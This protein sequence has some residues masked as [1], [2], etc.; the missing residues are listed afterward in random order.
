[1]NEYLISAVQQFRYYKMLGDKTMAQLSDDELSWQYNEA[2][3]SMAIMV[4][5]LWG[6]MMSRWTNFLT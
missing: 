5:H 1:M 2:S 3:N 6:N 4:K